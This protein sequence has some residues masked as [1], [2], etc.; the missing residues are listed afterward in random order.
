[1]FDAKKEIEG[2]VNWIRE[3]FD[4]NGKTANAVIGLSGGKDS[5]IVATILVKALGRDRVVGVMMPNGEQSDINDSVAIAKFL[6]IKTYTVNIGDPYN[7]F[8]DELQKS[9]SDVELNAESKINLAP[10]LRMSTLYAIAQS[11][12][13]GG[14]VCNTCNASEDYVGYS[15]KYGD[16]AGDFSPCSYYTVEEMLQLGDE[17]GVPGELV[18]K[19]PS[20][21]LSGKSD[22]DKLGFT[23]AVLDKYIKTG[24]CVDE[25]TKERIDRLHAMNLHKLQ[26]IPAYK[27]GE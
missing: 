15:T 24:V 14:R 23:Y 21:G 25:K 18:H 27:R 4:A 12:P 1:M 10:R 26:V 11:L 20:D 2:I 19:T 9:V 7:A 8:L 16:A 17:L 22:E 3:W 6:D 5:S 13:G